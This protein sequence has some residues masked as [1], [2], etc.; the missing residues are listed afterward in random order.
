MWKV[1]TNEALVV[2]KYWLK[3]NSTVAD[4]TLI[5]VAAWTKDDLIFTLERYRIQYT[6][7]IPVFCWIGVRLGAFFANSL[8]CR[9]IDLILRRTKNGGWKFGSKLDQRW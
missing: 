9:D 6:C 4:L 3:H 2:N 1:L 7:I 5:V 8:R